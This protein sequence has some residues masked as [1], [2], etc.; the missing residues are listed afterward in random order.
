MPE[1]LEGQIESITFANEETGYA[2]ARVR[3]AGREDRVTAVGNLISPLPGERVRLKGEWSRHP[4]YGLQFKVSECRA[5]AP[6]TAQGI[7]KYLGSGQIKGI[8]PQMARRIV[9]RFAE[10]TLE[11]I[12]REPQKLAEVE[13]IGRKR[14]AL[15]RQAWDCQRELREV[16]VFLQSHGLSPARAAALFRRYGRQAIQRVRAN[17]YRLA[18]EIFGIGFLTADRIASSLGFARDSA[19]RAEAGLLHTLRQAAEEGH[20]CCPRALLL[21]RSRELLQIEEEIISRA[22]EGLARSGKIIVETSPVLP[23]G[24]RAVYLPSYHLAE[25]GSA[26]ALK[27]LLGHPRASGSLFQPEGAETLHRVQRELGIRLAEQQEEALRLALEK[28]L[29]VVTGGPGTGKTTIMKALLAALAR[30]ALRVMLAAPTGRAAK[31]LSEVSG[32]EARTIH[33]LLEFDQRSGGFQRGPQNPLPCELLIVDE[34]SMIDI[35]LMHQLLGALPPSS[36]L[37]LVGDANQLPSVGAGNVL[38]DIIASG[39]V[40]VVELREIFRQARQSRIVVNA[41]RILK[42]R[43]PELEQGEGESDFYFIEQEDPERAAGIVLQLV[44]ERIPRKFQ[45][46]PLE[47]IQ[48]LAPMHKG[49][50]GVETLN[51]LLQEAL[52]SRR[53]GI[54]R[55]ESVFKIGDRVMQLRND[56]ERQ[57]FNGDIGRVAGIDRE[58]QE[59]RVA[60]EG[61]TVRFAFSQTDDLGLAYA[62]SIHKAQGCEFPAVVVP[63]L[64]QH[65]PLLQRNL[66]YTAVTRGRRLVVLVGSRKALAIA[67]RN[68]RPVKRYTL[69][70]ERLLEPGS[71]SGSPGRGFPA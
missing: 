30:T 27:A 5:S 10:R 69:L 38:K 53:D 24:E 8:G 7:E 29:L 68:D 20:A 21:A 13:G 64:T 33:R 4:Q 71:G 59:L 26:L 55:G 62:V 9:A 42:G 2:V 3:V 63:L 6:V 46:D 70:R 58:L 23:N 37:I 52:N 48:V 40:P 50:V 32:R 60:F 12:E 17:P 54:Q 19:A 66:L 14:I 41:H 22:L 31:R 43:L 36:S 44:R 45:L 47:D 51:R 28:K 18:E 15:I 67:V 57:V 25:A 56:Y 34:A 65:F 49:S 11:V 35:L 61:R 1:E 16:M 39:L